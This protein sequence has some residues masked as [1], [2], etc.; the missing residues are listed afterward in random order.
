MDDGLEPGDRIL[1]EGQ[2]AEVIHTKQV[3]ELPYV[4]VYIDGEGPKT[5]CIDDV[6]IQPQDAA[7]A[8]L[9]DIDPG[10]LHPGHEAVNADLFDLNTQALRLQL[11][12]EQGQLLSLN[13]SL[14]RLE[15][16]QL[17][18][19]NEAMDKLRQR[20]L[21]A[22]DVGLGKT[23][24]A[25][26]VFKELEARRRA[27]RV[28]LI[29]PAHL[30]KKWIR[31]MDRFFDTE[32]TKADRIWV[33]G[34]RRRLGES[35]NIWNQESQRLITSM[36]FLRQDEYEDALDEAFWDLVIVDEVHKA[37][38]RGNNP[39]TTSKRVEQVS[40]KSDALLL[41]SATPHDGK[42][43]SFR[44]LIS[45]ID[46]FLVAESEELTREM[47]D[48]VMIRR[49]KETIFDDEG[50]RVFP[51]RDVKTI[52]VTMTSEE[53]EFYDAV[54]AY[55]REVYNRSEQLNEPVVGFAMALMQKRLVSSIGAI[56]ETLRRRLQNLLEVDEMELSPQTRA[57]LEGDDL[58]EQAK[59]RVEE[60]LAR[61]TVPGGDADLDHE[62]NVLQELVQMA[63]N[64]PL[65]T[66]ATKVQRYIQ[67]LMEEQPD[68]KILI[69]TEYRD[70]L[71]HLLDVFEEEPWAGEILTIHGDV[72][73][74]KRSE[75]EDEFNYGRSRILLATDAASE[76]IDLQE[77]CHI[78]VNYEL[79]WNP[80]RLEQRIGR[81]HR[82]GQ[83]REVKV[84]NFQFQRPDGTPTREKE[85]FDLLQDKIEKIRSKVG[86]TADVLGM[87]DDLNV[88]SL[89][90][91]SL[92]DQKPPSAT[93]KEL[94]ELVEERE[95]TLLRWFDRS[96]IDC[97]T[98]DQESRQEIMDIVD[99]SGDLFGN[100]G[101]VRAFVTHAV[102]QL[103]GTLHRKG[104][105]TY[106]IELPEPLTHRVESKFLGGPVTFER[107]RAMEHRDIAYGSPDS[108][109]VQELM[110]A[111]EESGG[112]G[113]D[114]GL[115]VLPSLSEAGITFLYKAAFEDGTGE[116]LQ[117]EIIPV[118][119]D[120]E[121]RDPQRELGQE[122]ID[123]ASRQSKPDRTRV[124]R[125]LNLQ[126]DLREQADRY[127]SQ[128]VQ[129]E[130]NKL[131]T[132]RKQEAE[133]EL[134]HLEM[135]SEAERGRIEQFIETY[136]RKAAAG[137][138]MEIAIR[139][140][141][142]RLRKLEERIEGRKKNVQKKEQVVSLE[143]E[144]EAMCLAIPQ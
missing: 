57:Y 76:G 106:S 18:C 131:A 59:E 75:I 105:S 104:P 133:R 9:K 64:L 128:Y 86:N 37:A 7:P 8:S 21:I 114:L 73:K 46:P 47:V 111:V 25:G 132:E 35:A 125:L 17:A 107:E 72:D 85:I 103:G 94:E 62:I 78:M 22:D 129:R 42:E 83:D 12:H 19:V 56:R 127:I 102:R 88:D 16:Y 28:L 20:I 89:M 24:E 116:V 126:S 29:V 112:I 66:K 58:D 130:R 2:P 142:E 13:T 49:G 63:E 33:E 65:D 95:Q 51:D 80:N 81:I 32:L 119:V 108:S 82:Y 92:R 87:L 134:K 120:V 68:E 27:D 99:E 45:Y 123:S 110:A 109:L 90:M 10:D 69:F 138:D 4:R 121:A 93:R 3:G 77:S 43:D 11:A 61:V 124:S 74:E 31:D 140:Q 53:Q 137:R 54:S 26:L 39:S 115:K 1:L 14:V 144:L 91:E 98:F 79:P 122:V 113:N 60:E 141:K 135:Y 101:D 15:P 48:G 41:L 5:V 50:E 34:E 6:T 117:E 100:E 52:P 71:Q 70:T 96:L 118:F 139:G 30:Q 67:T 55:V 38:K 136:R 84:W 143:P 44:S 40:H 23:I 36:A 97:S